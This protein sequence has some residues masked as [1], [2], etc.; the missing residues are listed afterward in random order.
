MMARCGEEALGLATEVTALAVHV[1]LP[2]VN[3]VEVLE[4]VKTLPT[5]NP[6]ILRSERS[7]RGSA[8]C[9]RRPAF[10]LGRLSRKAEAFPLQPPQVV[11]ETAR[12]VWKSQMARLG[13]QVVPWCQVDKPLSFKRPRSASSQDCDRS[14]A[15][16]P[17]EGQ[18]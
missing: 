2:G 11:S 16:C 7:F 9:A 18:E 4:A 17:A 13:R 15:P 10:M 1:H 5:Q 8:H 12:A 6:I 3:D 14:S